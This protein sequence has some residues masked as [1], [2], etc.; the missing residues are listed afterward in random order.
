MG[1]S[2][3][4]AGQVVGLAGPTSWPNGL[5]IFLMISYFVVKENICSFG[6]SFGGDTTRMTGGEMMDVKVVVEWR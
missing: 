1:E 3:R 6:A 5:S 2:S 4:V